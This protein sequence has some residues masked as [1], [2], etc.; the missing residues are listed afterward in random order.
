[1]ICNILKI[2]V[3]RIHNLSFIMHHLLKHIPKPCFLGFVVYFYSKNINTMKKNFLLFFVLFIHFQVFSQQFTM[4]LLP[5]YSSGM[6]VPLSYRL[7]SGQSFASPELVLKNEGTLISPSGTESPNNFR[8][9]GFGLDVMFKLTNENNGNAWG[10]ILGFYRQTHIQST[11]I[12]TFN[13]KGYTLDKFVNIYRQTGIQVG[14]RREFGFKNNGST[15][16]FMQMTAMYS[17]SAEGQYDNRGVWENLRAGGQTYL[18]NG[19]G[20]AY[21]ATNPQTTNLMIAPEIGVVFKGLV[22]VEMSLSYQQSIGNPLSTERL[23]YY[24]GGAISGV[25]ET[26]VSPKSLWLNLR[27]PIKIYTHRNRP[28]LVYRPEPPQRKPELPQQR[29]QN[30]CITIR[31]KN[32]QKPLA[33]AKILYE[34]KVYYSDRDGKAQLSDLRIGQRGSFDIQAQNYR[35]GNIDF[36][37]IAQSGCQPLNV[38]LTF[39]QSPPSVIINGKVLKKGESITLNAIQFEQSKSD[40][41]PEGK[42]ELNTVVEIMRKY[43]SLSIELSGHTSAFK[44]DTQEDY[45]ANMD[46]SQ[47]RAEACK[48]FIVSQL[49]GNGSRIKTIGYGPNKPIV[50]NISEENRKKNRR[51]ELK[52]ES[53]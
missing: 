44:E 29:F 43:P 51:V 28:P 38:N 31:D 19:V 1:L 20:T 5:R 13:F 33:G 36:E 32:S 42:A 52:I 8:N 27:I 10:G 15:G 45:Q 4:H 16:Y 2:N 35:G 7:I 53:L 50:P 12:P 23:S 6:T 48:T 34:G 49:R 18:E 25:E 47:D 9:D 37:A 22:G 26:S 46:L 17:F 21:N 30:I 39:V 24:K 11:Q 3:L 14:L 40:L 41:L